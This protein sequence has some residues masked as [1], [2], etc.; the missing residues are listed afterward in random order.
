M[1]V[2]SEEDGYL[3]KGVNLFTIDEDFIPTMDIEILEG[4]NFEDSRGADTTTVIVN[5][6]LG[7]TNHKRQK[8]DLPV[9]YTY[10]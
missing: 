6:S 9:R 10:W 8:T 1:N 4:R 5:T 3:E 2:E 7:N